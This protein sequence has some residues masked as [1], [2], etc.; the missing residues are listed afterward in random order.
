M[1]NNLFA[2]AM[3]LALIGCAEK[4]AEQGAAEIEAANAARNAIAESAESEI[5]PHVGLESAPG[6]AFDYSFSFLLD[7]DRIAG[8]QQS[9]AAACEQLGTTRCR[10][11]NV[12]YG[13]S[14]SGNVEAKTQFL[15]DPGIARRFGAD[16]LDSVKELEGVLAEAAFAGEDVGS[17]IAASQQRSADANSEIK[18]IETRLKQP[19][20]TT[21]ERSEL[22]QRVSNLNGQ[23]DQEQAKRRDGEARIA[24]TSVAFRYTGNGGLPGIGHDNPFKNAGS[25]FLQSG[26]AALSLLLTVIATLLPWALVLALLIFIWR[27]GPVRRLRAS[28]KAKSPV[29][30]QE[31]SS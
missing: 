22:A 17:E 7:D 16:A 28:G 26:G 5:V 2:G 30:P 13:L 8:V 23:T 9:H 4:S 20:L 27:S 1:K 19:G 14:E 21:T 31:L 24:S 15:L 18:R 25:T 6:V 11:T 12:R 10:I 3:A 29:K